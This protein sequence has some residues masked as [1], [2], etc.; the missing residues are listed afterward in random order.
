MEPTPASSS[1][2]LTLHWW[3]YECRLVQ[4]PAGT[5]CGSLTWAGKRF[6]CHVQCLKNQCLHTCE[7]GLREKQKMEELEIFLSIRRRLQSDWGR[8]A[9]KPRFSACSLFCHPPLWADWKWGREGGRGR[10]NKAFTHIKYILTETVTAHAILIS[11]QRAQSWL[12]TYFAWSKCNSYF[13]V[14]MNS[15]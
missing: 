13:M 8:W 5:R 11:T 6:M 2:F 1:E 7:C 15:F 14:G 3:P 10:P 4:V 9:P 12:T